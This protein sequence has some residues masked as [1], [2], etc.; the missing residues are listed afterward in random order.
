MKVVYHPR[1]VDHNQYPGHPERPERL[2]SLMA[3]LK[4]EEIEPEVLTPEPVDEELLARVHDPD[5]I[6]RID[7]IG[8]G[9]YDPD[10]F[11]HPDTTQIAR[12][13]AGGGVLAAETA[14]NGDLCMGLMRPPGHHAGK[15][16]GGGFCYFN[17]IAIAAEHALSRG[18]VD[19]VAVI[20]IDGHHG[21]GTSDIFLER[22]DVLYMS[23][24]HYGIFP[25]TGAGV[26]LGRGEGSGFTL[27]FPFVMGCG[28]SSFAAAM[29]RVVTPVIAEFKPDLMLVSV[30]MDAHKHDPLTGLGLSSEGYME[31]VN[32]LIAIANEVCAGRLAFYLE[33]GYNLDIMAE[34][35]AAMIAVGTDKTPAVEPMDWAEN[36]EGS[37][38]VGDVRELASKFWKM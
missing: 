11:V 8:E 36:R 26:D 25:G 9:S 38:I 15:D 14:M 33:G 28:D 13:A 5:Y 1:Y 22:P 27:N 6:A 12:L 3:R 20:D 4:T 21:N 17:N 7:S 24:H 30:G 10:T 16:Y 34:V 23:T 19:R 29:D 2:V 35:G 31:T 18:D 37:R 32:D